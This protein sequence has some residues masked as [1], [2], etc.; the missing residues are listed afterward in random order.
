MCTLAVPGRQV[1]A[2]RVQAVLFDFDGVLV[3]S[4]PV[5]FRAGAQALAAI[6]VSLD[7]DQFSRCWLGRPDEAALRDILG[8]RFATDGG[9]V[10]ARRH[11]AYEA[12]LPQIPLFPDA[13]RLLQRLPAELPLAIASGSRRAEVEAILGRDGLSGRFPVLVTAGDYARAKPCPDPFLAA[14]SLLGVAAEH[15][16]VVEDSPA[17]IA[18]GGAAGM[19]VVAVDRHG[20][21][22]R[23][24][25]AP[26][27]VRSLD[28][29]D[30]TVAGELRMRGAGGSAPA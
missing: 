23:L 6:G 2:L 7:W 24:A 9:T 17:G 25:G 13:V 8:S 22:D 3:D 12:M 19:G 18:A 4:E 14:A 27:R 15:C 1:I 10:M 5:R 29:L 16:L 21:G 11:V 30:V 26:W 20:S 28:A